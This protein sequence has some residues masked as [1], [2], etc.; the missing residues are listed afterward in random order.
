[1]V[2]N[3][4][5]AKIAVAGGFLALGS[6]S[7]FRWKIETSIKQ[8][9]YFKLAIERLLASKT[10]VDVLGEPVLIGSIDLG[11]TKRN[12]CDGLQARFQVSVRGPKSSGI[13]AFE[14]S[15]NPPSQPEWRINLVELMDKEA[16]RKLVI[17][18]PTLLV[19]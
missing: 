18:S 8:S 10:A 5:L 9:T 6:A 11:D 7:Y 17:E 2:T 3:K 15:R 12:F 19:D 13:M 1:M 14:A 16:T 4:T